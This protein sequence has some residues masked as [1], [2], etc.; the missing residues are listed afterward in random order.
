MEN[1]DWTRSKISWKG[2]LKLKD[3]EFLTNCY[4]T[5]INCNGLRV[6]LEEKLAA[7]T[8][9]DVGIVFS[10]SFI[11]NA[12]VW[13]T[14]QKSIEGLYHYDLFFSKIEDSEKEKLIRFVR[15]NLDGFGR[16]EADGLASGKGAVAVEDHR[17]FARF[18]AKFPLRYLNLNDNKEGE[19]QIADISAKGLGF[20]SNEFLRSRTS[21][22]MWLNVPD[23]G[24]PLYTRGEVIWVTP[25]GQAGY[26]V[27]VRLERADLMG[28]SR[29]LRSGDGVKTA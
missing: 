19:A 24:E 8:S 14:L 10:S 11:V 29:I 20:V 17:T 3:K 2:K 21:L 22:E 28:V 12:Q 16:Q 25:H 13:V 27:G 5:D 23:G 26:R 15:T 6:C 9:L 7:D 4:I 1:K 18:S